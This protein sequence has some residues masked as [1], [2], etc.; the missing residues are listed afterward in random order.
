MKTSS[1][2]KLE[3]K[4]DESKTVKNFDVILKDIKN[5]GKTTKPISAKS[6]SSN[7]NLHPRIIKFLNAGK[8]VV[9]KGYES[10]EVFNIF[11]EVD[12]NRH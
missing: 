8:T 7:V 5:V 1:K 12:N 3:G 11:D 9:K 6:H 10:D 2:R 4:S